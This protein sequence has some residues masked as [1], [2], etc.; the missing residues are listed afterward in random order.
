VAVPPIF[1]LSKEIPKNTK[2]NIPTTVFALIYLWKVESAEIRHQFAAF[3]FILSTLDAIMAIWL[4][5]PLAIMASNGHIAIWSLW[6]Q[7]L[8]NE[9]QN[10]PMEYFPLYFWEFPF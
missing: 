4:Y 9:S 8:P 3:L 6:R 1:A 5:G 10:G 2:E 7:R